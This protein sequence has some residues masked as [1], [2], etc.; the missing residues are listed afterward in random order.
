MSLE[1]VIW[2]DAFFST[3][4]SEKK[5]K[6]YLVKTVGWTKAEKKFL[7]VRSERL[8]GKEGWRAITRIPWDMIIK[9]TK[10]GETE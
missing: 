5:R 1:L 4:E 7:V 6:D 8:P 9:R 10:L 2:R 3:D